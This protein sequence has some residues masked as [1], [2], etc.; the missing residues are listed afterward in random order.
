MQLIVVRLTTRLVCNDSSN[1]LIIGLSNSIVS[2]AK[3]LSYVNV[4]RCSEGLV[5][6]FVVPIAAVYFSRMPLHILFEYAT[7]EC[8][9]A[10]GERCARVFGD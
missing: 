6:H 7:N 8:A 5:C 10:L 9:R 1:L 4:W 3:L 2:R